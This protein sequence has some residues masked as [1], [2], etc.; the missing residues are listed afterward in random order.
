MSNTENK[1]WPRGFEMG[2]TM[3]S[4]ERDSAVSSRSPSAGRKTAAAKVDWQPWEVAKPGA[5][6]TAEAPPPA[7]HGVESSCLVRPMS[8]G[9]RPEAGGRLRRADQ[10]R[11]RCGTA[12]EAM[13][14]CALGV[15][16]YAQPQRVSPKS[17]QVGREGQEEA[18][19]VLRSLQID[20][21]NAN[22]SASTSIFCD[23]RLFPKI[24][25][26]GSPSQAKGADA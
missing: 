17:S 7:R 18:L 21:P 12:L 13:Q 1:R 5:V 24:R 2:R 11:P 22:G 4:C 14:S 15:W 20:P 3:L 10:H 9:E 23:G 19:G 6:R 16:S 25:A 8:R 26:R